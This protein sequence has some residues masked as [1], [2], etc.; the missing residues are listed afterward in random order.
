MPVVTHEERA[1]TAPLL[2]QEIGSQRSPLCMDKVVFYCNC[3]PVCLKFSSS[4]PL[5]PQT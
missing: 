2:P 1:H 5:V 4:V 3:F